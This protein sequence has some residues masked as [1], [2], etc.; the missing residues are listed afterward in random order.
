[1]TPDALAAEAL[2]MTP[3]SH[4]PYSHYA[5]GAAL[6]DEKGNVYGGVNVENA[7]YG[8]TMCAERV[9]IGNAI[10]DGASR[11]TALAIAVAHGPTAWPCGACRQVLAEFCPPELEIYLVSGD[12]PDRIDRDTLGSLLPRSFRLETGSPRA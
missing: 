11:F 1:M 10:A 3:R 9:A 2:A 12:N 4:S 6:L 8:L 7:S 5:V